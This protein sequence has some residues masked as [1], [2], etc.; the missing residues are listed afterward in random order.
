MGWLLK[1]AE[2]GVRDRLTILCYHRV[3]P[4]AMRDA[5]ILP[6]LVVTPESFRRHCRVVR[7]YYEVLPLREAVE[8]SRPGPG[9]ARP[10]A[11]ITFDDGYRDNYRYAAPIL[12][13]AGLKATFFIISDLVGRERMP[14]YDRVGEAIRTLQRRKRMADVLRIMDTADGG[15]D[16]AS[17]R[18]PDSLGATLHRIKRLAPADRGRL[19]EAL[20]A[21]AGGEGPVYPDDRI[22]TPEQLAN[23]ARRGHEIGS[24]GCS[25]E[26]LTQRDDAGLERETRESR[27]CLAGWT[28]QPVRSF[29]YPNGDVDDRVVQAVQSAGY[30]CAVT[31]QSGNNAPGQNR[32]RLRRWFIHEQRLTGV[33]EAASVLL[34]R[35]ELCGLAERVFRRKRS[36]GRPV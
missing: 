8:I 34:L 35:M 11:A 5:Y 27:R 7:Q 10:L 2:H 26:I 1:R 21:A 24:H 29:C 6:D 30:D 14:W 15:N 36:A 12:D 32:Y 17:D 3:L 20:I 13:E 28:G 22:M 25:H 23:L 4:A 19:V 31:V 16:G 33:Y 18:P 9:S